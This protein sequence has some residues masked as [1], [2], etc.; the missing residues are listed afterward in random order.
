M[1]GH[2][3]DRRKRMTYARGV[4][5]R[6]DDSCLSLLDERGGPF[7]TDGFRGAVVAT[8]DGWR[9]ESVG[10]VLDDG[11]RAALPVL[12]RDRLADSVPPSGYGGVV[13]SRPLAPEE[14]D[15]LLGL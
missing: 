13:A 12:V 8:V 3:G 4:S 1:H 11:T 10:A 2:S 5:W 14:E 9:D 6:R 7:S 15:A